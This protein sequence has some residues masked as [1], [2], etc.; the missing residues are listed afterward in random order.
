MIDYATLKLIWWAII[1]VLTIGFAV[2]GGFDLGVG[3]LLPYVGRNDD[4][5]RVAINAIGPTWEGNQVWLVTLGGALFAAWPMVYAAAFSTLYIALLLALFALF[6]RPAGF[7]Y[8]NKL[9]DP[10]WRTGWDWGLFVGGAVPATVFGVA[11]GNLFMGLPFRLDDSMRVSQ[12]GGLLSMLQPF[13]LFCGVL[14]LAMLVTHGASYLQLRAVGAVQV[15]ARRAAISGAGLVIVL[16]AIGGVW[17]A[18]RPGLHIA[19]MGNPMDILM[20]QTKQVISQPGGWLANYHHYPSLWLL[21]IA[22][23]SMAAMVMLASWRSWRWAAWLA[24]GATCAAIIATTAAALFPFVLP[25]SVDLNSS[26]TLWDACSSQLTL[27]IMLWATAILMPIVLAYTSWVY[28]VMRGPVSV[29]K[30]REETHTAY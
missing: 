15:R 9:A 26:L 20:P 30:I 22:G 17:L 21:P 3:A 16:F 12:E 29:E 10:R 1:C 8:R 23:I 28:H 27:G 24:S 4:E 25:S 19:A 6:L 11:V 7:D 13:A 14:S 5:R 18:K 2:T